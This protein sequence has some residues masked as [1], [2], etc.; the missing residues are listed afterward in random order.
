MA[1]RPH[2][3][4][5]TGAAGL[6]EGHDCSDSRYSRRLGSRFLRGFHDLLERRGQ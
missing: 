1:G 3:G 2:G 5:K 4:K 6:P